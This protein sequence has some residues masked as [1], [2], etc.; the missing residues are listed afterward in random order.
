[1]VKNLKLGGAMIWAL[2]L[3]D[4]RNVC[5]GGHYT[6]LSTISKGLTDTSPGKL[7]HSEVNLLSLMGILLVRI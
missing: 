6:L 3:D 2:D 7:F 1:M 4:F 5:G